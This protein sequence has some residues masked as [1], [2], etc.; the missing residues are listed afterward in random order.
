VNA[1]DVAA[2]IAAGLLLILAGPM[3]WAMWR[4]TT[5]S[6]RLHP[7]T[8]A[9]RR[10]KRNVYTAGGAVVIITI[11]LELAAGER[12]SLVVIIAIF[13]GLVLLD[14]IL[15]PWL[16]YRRA[17]RRSTPRGKTPA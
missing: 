5:L 8:P 12:T 2:L 10:R 3:F 16:H 11:A 1:E 4:S 6:E 15:T 9:Q 13:G 14:A 7:L 17:K